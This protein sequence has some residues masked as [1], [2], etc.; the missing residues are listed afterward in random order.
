M[1]FKEKSPGMKSPESSQSKM[2]SNYCC[3]SAEKYQSRLEKG[4][5][6][7]CDERYG[8][9]HRC[10]SKQLQVL[11][12][13]EEE[14]LEELLLE[15]QEELKESEPKVELSRHSAAGLNSPKTMKVWG[16][17]KSKEVVILLDCG[18]THN[19]IARQLVEELQLPVCSKTFSITLGNGHKA[20]GM[21]VSKDVEFE[22]QGVIFKQNFLPFNLGHID[23]ILGIEW[24][25]MLREDKANWS[26]QT[27]KFCWEG[28]P[29]VLQGD[30]SISQMEVSF[31]VI[32]KAV[33]RGGQG[34]MVEL[35]EMGV[36]GGAE[37]EV[38]PGLPLGV[39][40][41]LDECQELFVSP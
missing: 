2:G 41:L 14:E 26:V 24:L 17:I 1:F 30:L 22:L 15:S 34:F 32:L 11:I 23:V 7:R 40:D 10:K 13:G 8:L 5:C 6:F 4:L 9:N 12:I 16:H 37:S 35:A 18:A 29:V 20:G 28:N 39:E 3:L 21:G 19:F 33:K 38:T 25:Q 27:M 36:L 31:H